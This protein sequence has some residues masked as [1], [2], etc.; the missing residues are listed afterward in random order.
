[1][2]K[3]DLKAGTIVSGPLFPE[4]IQVVLVQEF[5]AS[6]RMFGKGL[7]SEKMYDP[8]LTDE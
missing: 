8:I 6:V 7:R 2:K 3:I 5:G 1:M 4:P